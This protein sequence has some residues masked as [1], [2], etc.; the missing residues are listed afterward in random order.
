MVTLTKGYLGATEAKKCYLGSTLVL[1]NVAAAGGWAQVGNTFASPATT[2]SSIAQLTATSISMQNDTTNAIETYS[3]DGTDFS[4]IGTAFSPITINSSNESSQLANNEIVSLREG[5]RI[6]KY[7]HDG[8]AY[9]R[10]GN[11]LNF[12]A[13]NSVTGVSS[14]RCAVTTANG[15]DGLYMFDH[16][17]TNW[18]QTGST[19]AVT[20]S[21]KKHAIVCLDNTVDA[22]RFAVYNSVTQDIRIYDFNGTTFSQVGNALTG[23][24]NLTNPSLAK[25][26]A[27]DFAFMGSTSGDL[28]H[29]SFDGT[30]CT[31]NSTLNIAG[32]SIVKICAKSATEIFYFGTSGGIRVYE[33]T[34]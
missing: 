15:T 34:P 3:W 29:I 17:G 6:A 26:S 24:G 30:D 5:S 4:E 7:T 32:G 20:F 16:D 28:R 12:A 11:E 25:M 31:I 14:T 23:M 21:F 27:T 8:T 33:Y 2:E 10:I 19:L 1:D 22:E 9:T 13:N 18:S